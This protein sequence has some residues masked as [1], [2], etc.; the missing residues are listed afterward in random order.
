MIV[1][2]VFVARVNAGRTVALE[3]LYSFPI[4]TEHV[5]VA[6]GAMRRDARAK[7]TSLH[8]GRVHT[9]AYVTVDC[10]PLFP[11]FSLSPV[12]SPC[13]FLSPS[14]PH[15]RDTPLRAATRCTRIARCTRESAPAS[16]CMIITTAIIG[17]LPC[18]RALHVS[19]CE[20]E[21]K[22]EGERKRPGKETRP[23]R[24]P[25]RFKCSTTR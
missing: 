6:V 9:R 1:T 12:C 10:Q 11:S 7:G 13:L 22:G 3:W 5:V 16:F 23:P 25:S 4:D 21:R 15:E 8:S 17:R 14:L 2:F 20:S 19:T 24:F 18:A